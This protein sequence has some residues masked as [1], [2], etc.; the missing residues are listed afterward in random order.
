MASPHRDPGPPPTLG[1][2]RPP[3]EAQLAIPQPRS[4]SHAAA[5]V[6]AVHLA[7]AMGLC[8]YEIFM[9]LWLHWRLS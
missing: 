6:R 2:C 3:P 4:R 5:G 1:I 9:V 8:G 7:W